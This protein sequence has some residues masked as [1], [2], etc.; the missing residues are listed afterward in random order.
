MSKPSQVH[1]CVDIT[2][3]DKHIKKSCQLNI[4]V[5]IYICVSIIDSIDMFSVLNCALILQK[6]IIVLSSIKPFV[7]LVNSKFEL[8]YENSIQSVLVKL[9]RAQKWVITAFYGTAL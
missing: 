5:F 8:L 3:F 4:S 9:L 1:D 6:K 2:I 7:V